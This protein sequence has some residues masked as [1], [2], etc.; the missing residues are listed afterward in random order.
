MFWACLR[1]LLAILAVAGLIVGPFT[2]PAVG[3]AAEMSSM[4][5][6][7]EEDMS[8]DMPCCPDGTPAVPD[9]QKSCPLMATCMAKCATAVPMLSHA[10]VVSRT[11]CD[12]LR[13]ASDA[14]GDALAAELPARPP[15]T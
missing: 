2:A 10:G 15:R 11:E 6:G 5:A 1:R 13:P 12:A 7:M 9:C 8:R 3:R 4:I 14:L